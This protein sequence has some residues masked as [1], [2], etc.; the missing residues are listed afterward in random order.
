MYNVEEEYLKYVENVGGRII[1]SE[2][3]MADIKKTRAALGITQEEIGK[4]VKLR[5]ETISRI[6]N[7]IINPTFEFVKK[8]KKTIAVAK[9]IRD[10]QALEEVLMLSGRT[11]SSLPPSLL[12]L[13]FNISLQDLK[14]ASEI[15]VRSYQRSKAKIIKK[16]KS[17]V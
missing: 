2:N 8:K 13:C 5:R 1:S 9:V 4:L 7:G 17:E 12:R 10:L 6:E 15:G 14:L 11:A 3:P 16:I